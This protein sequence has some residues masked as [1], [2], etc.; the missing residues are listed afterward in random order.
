VGLDRR[1]LDDQLGRYLTIGEP[2]REERQHV[3]LARREL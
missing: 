1:L 3:A 2:A